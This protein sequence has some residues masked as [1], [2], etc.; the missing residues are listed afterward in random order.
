[1]TDIIK[2]V[3]DVKRTIKALRQIDP[4]HE[5]LDLSSDFTT[6]DG[7][8]VFFPNFTRAY[9]I[10]DDDPTGEESIVT[11]WNAVEDALLEARAEA[12][13]A[14]QVTGTAAVPA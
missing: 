11:Y 14:I 7:K 3:R 9:P 6:Q 12:E 10:S 8:F 2:L 4:N 5:L 1:M 13:K